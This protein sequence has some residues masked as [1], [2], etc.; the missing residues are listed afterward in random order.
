MAESFLGEIRMFGGNFAPRQWSFCSG[1]YIS[2]GQNQALFSLFGTGYGGDGRTNFMLP[3]LRGRLPVGQGDGPGLTPRM[4]G[5]RF[6]VEQVTIT[7][8]QMPAHSHGFQIS[9]EQAVNASA[10]GN[11]PASLED[12]D[13]IYLTQNSPADGQKMAESS[14][15]STGNGQGHY[16]M[17]PY[18]G[19]SFIVS[20]AGLYP[21]RN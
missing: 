19:V 10:I 5:Q 18:L 8:Q 12:S 4:I 3:D 7:E 20:M 14:V 13:N 6:G 15:Q 17:M 16:N 9:Q 21:S 1:Q 2:I 11:V